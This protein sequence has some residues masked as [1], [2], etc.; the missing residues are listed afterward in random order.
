[1]LAD[2]H[3]H[4]Y[5]LHNATEVIE[6]ARN[7]G[8]Q[9]LGL[10]NENI[11]TMEESFPFKKAFPD[12]ILYGMGIYPCEFK[13]FQDEKGEEIRHYLIQNIFRADMMGEIG[14]DYLCASTPEEKKLQHELLQFQ[15]DLAAE[16]GLPV[17]LHSRRALRDTMNIAIQYQKKSGNPA[18]LH[19]FTQSRKL[20]RIAGEAGVFMSVGPRVLYSEDTAKVVAEIPLNCLLLETD[21]PVPFQGK[22]STPLMILDVAAK[23][24]EIKKIS[25]QE[26]EK[27]LEDNL[28]RY[29]GKKA[30]C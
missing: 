15:L 18:L 7:A 5:S 17:N 13:D 2:I 27:H 12:L 16:H 25:H 8:I 28:F 6:K 26:L 10:V 20:V 24:C 29:L 22:A 11:K 4:L 3:C 1:M 30:R 14:L 9:R 19:W 23:V 21:T